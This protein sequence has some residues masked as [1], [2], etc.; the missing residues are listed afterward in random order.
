[1]IE[2]AMT[3]K[4]DYVGNALKRMVTLFKKEETIPTAVFLQWLEPVKNHLYNFIYKAIY[5]SED[6]N[7]I[8]QD[9]VMRAFKYRYSYNGASS[10]KTWIFSIANNEIKQYYNKRK[11]KTNDCLEWDD[12][13]HIEDN[14]VDSRLV[15]DI[16]E[17]AQQL[18]PQQQRVFFLFYDDGFSIK[19]IQDITGL[20]EGNIKF[21]LNQAR[22]KIKQK[23]NRRN[24][25]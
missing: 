16:Y 20:K 12:N 22:E 17:V 15:H 4:P 14:T 3:I 2:T 9:T 8:Y 25:Q 7:D 19:E 13:C 1:M 23:L 11:K 6:A 5:F 18:T 24:E 10:F 21:I